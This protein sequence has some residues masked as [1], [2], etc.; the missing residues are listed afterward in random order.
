M[1]TKPRSVAVSSAPGEGPEPMSTSRSRIR[2]DGVDDA[3]LVGRALDGDRWAH[4]AIFRRY[5]D[6]VLGLATRMLGDESEADDVAQDTFTVA[7]SRLER[8]EDRA[9]LRSW[10]FGIAVHRVR[11]RYRA[12]RWLRFI[13]LGGE[14]ELGLFELASSAASPETRADLVLVD[15]LLRKLPSE[16]RIAWMLRVVEGE[17]LEDIALQTGASLATV[18]RRISAVEVRLGA[19]MGRG[20][21]P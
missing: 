7:L 21:S 15:G 14:A 3:T 18:K 10:L 6:D 2:A 19:M 4:E 16:E 9:R 5:I 13:G 11:R 12:R 8:L 20:S 1:S 17:T